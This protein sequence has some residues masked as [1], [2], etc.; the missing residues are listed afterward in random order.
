MLL[1][2]Y[3]WLCACACW[4]AAACIVVCSQPSYVSGAIMKRVSRG[5]SVQSQA[6]R[7]STQCREANECLMKVRH[8]LISDIRPVVIYLEE[9]MM[10]VGKKRKVQ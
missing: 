1:E 2:P 6:V 9:N 8:M 4:S 3:Y 7:T 5:A 10:S